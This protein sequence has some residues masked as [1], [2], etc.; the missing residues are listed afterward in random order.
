MREA[1]KCRQARS[2][3]AVRTQAQPGVAATLTSAALDRG[4][5]TTYGGSGGVGPGGD[6]KAL[7]GAKAGR[8][9][10][11]RTRSRKAAERAGRG[12]AGGR[13]RA[14]RPAP[15]AGRRGG[16][17]SARRG[18]GEHGT[19]AKGRPGSA[20]RRRRPAAGWARDGSQFTAPRPCPPVRSETTTGGDA[21]AARRSRVA[22]TEHRETWTQHEALQL[23]RVNSVHRP[24]L[25]Q[26]VSRQR[27][28]R[29]RRR[30][31]PSLRYQGGAGRTG[32]FRGPCRPPSQS[33]P[34]PSA[35]P[36]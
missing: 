3:V 22:T 8:W 17:G 28:S 19:G 26:Q 7:G 5:G 21:R 29:E 33:A 6:H 2:Q 32:A 12:G 14:R 18:S 31:R 35:F 34:S 30:L 11:T 1:G 10:G 36:P 4:R 20:R 27:G 25:T 13:R 9:S 23:P 24:L 15:R 16:E